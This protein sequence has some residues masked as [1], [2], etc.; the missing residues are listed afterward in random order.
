MVAA[1]AGNALYPGPSTFPPVISRILTV[2][3]QLRCTIRCSIWFST[4]CWPGC[5]GARNS[6]AKS[7]PHTSSVTRYS[8]LLWRC[9][10]AKFGT[11]AGQAIEE[12]RQRGRL[13][14][15]CGGT[16]LYLKAL[17]DGLGQAPAGNPAIR[18]ELESTPLSTLL[19]ELAQRDPRCY[20]QI[21]RQNR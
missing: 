20:E 18:A 3:I 1:T 12:I 2:F 4:S 21:D 7:S 14:I 19:S 13:P 9:F 17:L 15:L 11:R 16:G 8:A 10:A 5:I 6:M